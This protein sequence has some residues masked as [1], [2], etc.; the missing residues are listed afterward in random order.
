MNFLKSI[1]LSISFLTV[2]PTGAGGE[3]SRTSWR[4]F[5]AGFPIAGYILGVVSFVPAWTMTA[6]IG[7]AK[8]TSLTAQPLFLLAAGAVGVVLLLIL[9]RGL[10]IDGLADFVDGL[11]ASG[12]ANRRLTVMKDPATGSFAAATI[13]ATLFLKVVSAAI[14]LGAGHVWLCI[15]AVVLA[16]FFLAVLTVTGRYART[17]GTAGMSL[18]HGRPEALVAAGAFVL[19]C[20]L[21]PYVALAAIAMVAVTAAIRFTANRLFGGVTGD[22]L[23]ADCEICETIGLLIL[24]AAVTG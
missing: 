19:P 20:L 18:N 21:S 12:T 3:V 11:G 9:T 10:H 1:L 17:S 6:F 13:F 4:W 23:G 8:S 15:A 24:A 2:F 5:P 7:D 16:R 14:L 22:I